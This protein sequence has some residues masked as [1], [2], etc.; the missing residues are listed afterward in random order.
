MT[1]K[2][3]EA[4]LESE[5]VEGYTACLAS[6]DVAIFFLEENKTEL[7]LDGLT[8]EEYA[9]LYEIYGIITGFEVDA[10]GNIASSFVSE[11]G[12]GEEYFYYVTVKETEESFW[13]VQSACLS[14]ESES[15]VDVFAQWHATIEEA[16]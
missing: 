10:Y 12:D 1:L 2:N 5:T 13:L 15:Y 6:Y 16:K 11:G 3:A 9:E 8:L 7:D 4:G 14:A